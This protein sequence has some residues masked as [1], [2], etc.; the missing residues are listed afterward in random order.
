MF[1][2]F[3]DV[4]WDVWVLKYTKILTTFM[5]KKHICSEILLH[6]S[7]LHLMFI[8]NAEIV[9]LVNVHQNL[10]MFYIFNHKMISEYTY[11]LSYKLKTFFLV[12]KNFFF[13]FFK[14]TNSFIPPFKNKVSG[15]WCRV[16]GVLKP[17]TRTFTKNS[18]SQDAQ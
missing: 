16:N 9:T 1:F 3:S 12:L 15:T 17:L 11:Q 4:C 10:V 14:C 13:F 7:I 8:Y 2:G 6:S 18:I 5:T